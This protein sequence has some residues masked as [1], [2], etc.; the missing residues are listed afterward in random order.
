MSKNPTTFVQRNPLREFY[1]EFE[2]SK[3][4]ECD[5]TKTKDPPLEFEIPNTN[6][7][8]EDLQFCLSKCDEAG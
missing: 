1:P 2:F 4:F 3:L 7:D 8:N 5:P 6:S